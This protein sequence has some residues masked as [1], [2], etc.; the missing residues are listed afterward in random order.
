MKFSEG[1][2]GVGSAALHVLVTRWRDD[3]RRLGE[4]YGQ[5]Q[6]ARVLKRV[7]DDLEAA[8]RT[9]DDE[10]LNLREASEATGYHEDHLGRLVKSGKIPNAGRKHAPRIRRGDLPVKQGGGAPNASGGY[11]K[12]RLFQHIVDSK[13]GV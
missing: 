13:F 9:I 6:V 1:S 7:A 11:D 2:S 12:G 3:A 8:L 5:E 10:V 4:D